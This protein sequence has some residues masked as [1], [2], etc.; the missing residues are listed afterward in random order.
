ML[1]LTG[2]VPKGFDQLQVLARAGAGDL[3]EH[4]STLTALHRLSNITTKVNNV[5][6][7]DFL[8]KHPENP[9]GYVAETAK[10]AVFGPQLSNSGVP[11]ALAHCSS[12][13]LRDGQS[14]SA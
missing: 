10:I 11:A 2:I 13:F 5:P 12:L 7:Q 6:L 8:Q 4:A 1:G 14:K 3:E 9:H